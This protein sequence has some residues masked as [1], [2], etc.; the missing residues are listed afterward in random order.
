[1][2]A[3]PFISLARRLARTKFGQNAL[4]LPDGQRFLKR[5]PTTRVFCGLALMALSYLT[6]LPSLVILSYFSVKL[7]KPTI[8]AIG[9]PVIFGLVHVMFG[10]GVYLAGKNY[11]MEA[12]LWATKQFLKKY[13]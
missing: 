1:M 9:G 10:V 12:L 3:A 8:I 13:A 5:K 6:G 7:S 11:A 4:A 2:K